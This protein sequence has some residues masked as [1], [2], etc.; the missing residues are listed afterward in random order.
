MNILS[1]NCRGSGRPRTVQDLVCLVQTHKP[2]L[3]F[4][5]ETHQNTE[6]VCGLKWRLGLRN[7]VAVPG[8]G[9]GEGGWTSPLLG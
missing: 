8:E 2:K 6:R 9:T 5:S 7:C 3:V 1:W 4:L